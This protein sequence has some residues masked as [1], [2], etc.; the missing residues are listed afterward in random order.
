MAIPKRITRSSFPAWV[1]TVGESLR[2]IAEGERIEIKAWCHGGCGKTRMVDFEKLCAAEG[3]DYSLIDRRCRCTLTPGC[4]GW[5]RFH[6]K[7]G[8]FR[9]LWTDEAGARWSDR[10]WKASEA[11]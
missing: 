11:G 10:D 1:Q 9:P 2:F 5:V 7:L 4:K 8:V 3:P 6:Y